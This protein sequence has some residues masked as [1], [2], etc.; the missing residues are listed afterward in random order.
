MSFEPDDG[1]NMLE[2]DIDG[3]TV[4]VGGE[5]DAYTAPQVA[6]ALAGVTGDITLD[7]ADVEFIDS[8]GLRVILEFHQSVA[9]R[10]A[11]FTVANP[12]H[13]VQRLFEISSV[14]EYLHIRRA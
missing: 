2:I 10:G 1:A 11:I 4:A 13:A 6:G 14:D 7:L 8:S 12:S 5:I 3:S 9:E